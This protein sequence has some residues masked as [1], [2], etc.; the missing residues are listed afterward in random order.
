MNHVRRLAAL[1][2]VAGGIV[3]GSTRATAGDPASGERILSQA[4][5]NSVCEHFE[6]IFKQPP[7]VETF[8][9]G[10]LDV[11]KGTFAWNPAVTFASSRSPIIPIATVFQVQ[12]I[13]SITPDL[14]PVI[15]HLP[16]GSTVLGQVGTGAMV[17]HSGAAP[18][19]ALRTPAL[20]TPVN[21]GQVNVGQKMP[22]KAV[23]STEPGSHGPTIFN[24]IPHIA[25]TAGGLRLVFKAI[26][27]PANVRLI[28]QVAGGNVL[29]PSSSDPNA[30]EVY[31]PPRGLT[32][33]GISCG[34][35][36][37]ANDLH[38]DRPPT[39][40]C[41]VL[42]A[43]PIAYVYEPPGTGSSQAYSVTNT[44]GTVL[45]SFSGQEESKTHDVQTAFSTVG[46]LI[47][48]LKSVGKIVATAYPA[49]GQGMQTA[50]D[51]LSGAWG[52]SET[53]ATVTLNVTQ[54]HS[55]ETI[56]TQTT[57]VTTDSHMGPGKGDAIYY[58]VRPH[59]VWLAASDEQTGQVF[60]TVTLLGFE[61]IGALSAQNL[62]DNMNHAGISPEAVALLLAADP[63]AAEYRPSGGATMRP[64]GG[65]GIMAGRLFL[66]AGLS[67]TA[68]PAPGRLMEAVPA[69]FDF[70]QPKLEM[71]VSHE[72]KQTDTRTET[73]TADCTTKE[74]G[75]VASYFFGD[76]VPQTG[77]NS[78]S[79]VEG[80][81]TEA[82]TGKTVDVHFT[83]QNSDTTIIHVEAYY[84]AIYGTFALIPSPPGQT[85]VSGQAYR[86]D[87]R[88]APFQVIR[89]RANGLIHEARADAQGRFSFRDRRLKPGDY[90][91]VSGTVQQPMHFDGKTVHGIAFHL[92]Q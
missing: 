83:L 84:D 49:V 41:F 79:T 23:A 47:T 30:I 72:I 76:K 25:V 9:V 61:G 71:S 26:N 55:L 46:T 44:T 52:H 88:P 92:K 19:G 90:T 24:D 1:A 40:G 8:W 67:A 60:I 81:T 31:L 82:T 50:S 62:R 12:G 54:D 28:V 27:R 34:N 2:L 66:P 22:L 80:S 4:D 21:V 86:L 77:G 38:I 51:I 69:S 10:T 85:E 6:S 37:Y 39:L 89:L 16:L 42:E 57:S 73:R 18:A 53:S 48:T 70:G 64:G 68:G 32:R 13:R 15:A 91:L 56:L 74:T 7:P 75:G 14:T 45:K 59:F 78:L 65:K 33:F 58:M 5:M 3:L 35:V 36:T 87:G 11:A 29:G 20:K 43:Y 63:L 17:V